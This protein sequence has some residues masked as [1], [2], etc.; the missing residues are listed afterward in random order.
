MGLA[1]GIQG[2]REVKGELTTCKTGATSD[3]R[4]LEEYAESSEEAD[5]HNN[6]NIS[7]KQPALLSNKR[8]ERLSDVTSW[9][10]RED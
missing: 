9:I 5:N 4:L 3:S 6:N 1:A 10:T 8:G 2:L 7:G